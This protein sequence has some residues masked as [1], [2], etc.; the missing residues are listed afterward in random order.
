MQQ[1]QKAGQLL[2]G[3][4]LAEFSR[5]EAE[6]SAKTSKAKTALDTLATTHQARTHCPQWI[7]DAP[8]GSLMMTL[9]CTD[10]CMAVAGALSPLSTPAGTASN[11]YWAFCHSMLG[12]GAHIT[13]LYIGLMSCCL[14][15][16][17]SS[18]ID[19]DMPSWKNHQQEDS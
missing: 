4:Q 9:C 13:A 18:M 14:I 8:N 11:A 12:A 5:L 7:F 2:H 19:F 17:A 3:D 6:A 10:N 1:Q 15:S 16:S